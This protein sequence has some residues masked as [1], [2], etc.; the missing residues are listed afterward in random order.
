MSDP[1][2]VHDYT[3]KAR[4]ALKNA[5]DLDDPNGRELKLYGQAVIDD[6]SASSAYNRIDRLK[7]LSQTLD[8]PL[9]DCDE[10]DIRLAMGDLA[11]K[12]LGEGQTYKKG[13]KRKYLETAQDFGRRRDV[14]SLKDV[15]VPSTNQTPIDE[16]FTLSKSEVWDLIENAQ[17]IRTK[18]I[19]AVCWECAWRASALMSLKIKDYKT[20]TERYAL[21][22]APTDAIGLKEADGDKKPLTISTAYLDNWLAEHPCSDDPNAALFCRTDKEQ[23]YGEHLSNEAVRKQLN[24]AAERAD[25]DTERVNVH[26]FRHARSTYMKKSDEYD[27]MHIETTLDWAEGTN[28]HGRYEHLNQDDKVNSLLRARGIDPEDDPM[29]PEEQDCPRCQREIPYDARVCPYCNLIVDDTP[30]DWF[31]LYRKITTETDPV[32]QKY[33]EI[34]SAT[35]VFHQLSKNEFDHVR[36]MFYWAIRHH[37]I[38]LNTDKVSDRVN[39]SLDYDAIE[40]IEK[41]D[42]DEMSM[43]YVTENDQVA[44]NY[45][46]NTTDYKLSDT[47]LVGLDPEELEENADDYSPD[48]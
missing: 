6:L 48:Q 41:S 27:D 19:I 7:R 47:E 34:A 30:T 33:D 42:I 43:E 17:K 10:D 9:T 21:L 26:A 39:K 11:E 4:K 24:K 18:A 5:K 38:G 44:R 13:T 29:E 3:G 22:K 25:I 37:D 45:L 35:P 23:H 16:E 12:N 40:T 36:M 14:D 8:K 32:R 15:D 28:Q 46:E 1:L 2:D 31:H 20:P